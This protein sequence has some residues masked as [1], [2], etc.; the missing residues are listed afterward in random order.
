[1]IGPRNTSIRHLLGQPVTEAEV[2]MDFS[3]Y[4]VW[5]DAGPLDTRPPE[6]WAHKI[7]DAIWEGEDA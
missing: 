4:G 2:L 5:G 7:H 1:M 3:D 6:F